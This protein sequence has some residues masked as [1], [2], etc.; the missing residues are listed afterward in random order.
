[1][2]YDDYWSQPWVLPQPE[3]DP[4]PNCAMGPPRSAVMIAPTDPPAQEDLILR[5]EISA[6]WKGTGAKLKTG[7]LDV[8][9]EGGSHKL[10]ELVLPSTISEP[11]NVSLPAADFGATPPVRAVITWLVEKP[12]GEKASINSP[13]LVFE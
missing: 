4:C 8:E 6:D 1:L 2:L 5:V 12:D 13:I 10:Y 7:T 9:L 11:W 3:D